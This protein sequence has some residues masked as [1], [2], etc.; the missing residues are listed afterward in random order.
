MRLLAV[1]GALAIALAIAAGVY[2]LGGFYSVAASQDDAGAVVWALTRVRNASIGRHADSGAPPV[3]LED[4]A[5][6]Q[7]GARRYAQLGCANC[8]GA[9]GTQWAKF[10]EGLN[11]GPPD[12]SEVAKDRS[13]VALFWVIKNGIRMTGMPSFAKA[14][15]Q[16]KD[17]WQ[18]VAF[19][20]KL[21]GVKEA[22]YKSWTSDA[23]PK[24]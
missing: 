5:T 21:P 3:V 13:P 1:I 19:V 2:L 11:P 15:A 14:G 8:H 20:K 12:L 17:I 16:D 18:I 7:E 10:S 22:D 9:P 24:Q 23:A 4:A 6:V